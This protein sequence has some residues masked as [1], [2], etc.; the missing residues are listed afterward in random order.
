M[1]SI[2]AP[3]TGILLLSLG[4]ASGFASDW[5]PAVGEIMLAVGGVVT[6]PA[7][8]GKR[9]ADEDH[10]RGDSRSNTTQVQATFWHQ[11]RELITYLTAALAVFG[12]GLMLSESIAETWL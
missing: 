2:M 12:A 6:L 10:P 3:V 7:V 8:L 1:D 9:W 4:I 11:H 5:P